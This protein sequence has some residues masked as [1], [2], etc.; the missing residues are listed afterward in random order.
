VA[1]L[2]V[3]GRPSVL[4][5]YRY[6]AD[7]HQTANAHALEAAGAAWVMPEDKFTVEALAEQLARLMQAP[8]LLREAAAR[9]RAL[10]RP[11]AAERLA[12]L[13]LDVAGDARRECPQ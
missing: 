11:D 3:T 2:T 4:V 5:P 7:D 6:A 1:E 8:E 9:A 12:D 10:G 13:V